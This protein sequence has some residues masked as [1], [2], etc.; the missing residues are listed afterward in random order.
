MLEVES[1][2]QGVATIGGAQK[3]AVASSTAITI[4][5]ITYVRVEA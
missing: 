3:S 2:A 5:T 4:A 1:L